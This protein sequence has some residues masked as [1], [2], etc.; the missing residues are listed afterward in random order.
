MDTAD[1]EPALT[2]RLHFLSFKPWNERKRT[3]DEIIKSLYPKLWSIPGINAFPFTPLMLPGSGGSYPINFAV[4]TMGDYAEL[5]KIM[6]QLVKAAK[7]NPRLMNVD[8]DLKMDQSQIDIKVDRNKVGDMGISIGD[9]GDAISMA[10]GEPEFNWFTV[11]GRSYYVIPQLEAQ[12]RK[13]PE[14][15]NWLYLQPQNGGELVPLSNLVSI[16]E[17][18]PTAEP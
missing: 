6:Q 7:A 2:V 15:L 13:Q 5:N 8:S 18:R 3:A 14:T 17:N 10:L 1:P 4:E 9:V 16:S 11:N 12:Y